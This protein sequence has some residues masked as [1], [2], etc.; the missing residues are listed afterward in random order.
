MIC[1]N[2]LMLLL[3]LCWR[4]TFRTAP[5]QATGVFHHIP[6]TGSPVRVPPRR[7]P[8]NFKEK[9]ETL[10]DEMLQQGIIEESSSP[11]MQCS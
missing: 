9:V 8:A 1:P 7:I 5:G 10:L 11:W 6:T 2:V 3:R 4:S